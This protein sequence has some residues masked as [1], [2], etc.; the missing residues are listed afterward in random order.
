MQLAELLSSDQE[1]AS[2]T[3]RSRLGDIEAATW[4]TFQAL[5][6]NELGRLSPPAVRYIVHNYFAKEHGWLIKGLEPQGHRPNASEVHDV[7]VLQDKAPALVEAFLEDRRSDRGLVLSD[8]VAMIAVLERFI[9]DESLTLL[10]ASYTLNGKS[11]HEDLNENELHGVLQSYLLIFAQGHKATSNATRHQAYKELQIRHRPE[12]REY[13]HNAVLNYVYANRHTTN[14]FVPRRYTLQ[15]AAEIVRDMAHRYGK[16]QNS[17]C[18]QMKDHLIELDPTGFGRVP[19]SAFYKEDPQSVYHFSESVDYLR[20]IGALDESGLGGAK[21]LASNYILGP[22]NCIAVSD[23]YSVCCLNECDSLMNEL[24]RQAQAPAVAPER[25]LLLASQLSSDSVDAPREL[26]SL[27]VEKLHEIAALHGGQV[28]LHGRL[29]A[30]WLHYAF[31]FECPYPSRLESAQALTPSAWLD[32]RHTSD[33]EERAHHIATGSGASAVDVNDMQSMSHWTEDEILPLDA[34]RR[35]V[36]GAA[37]SMVLLAV[38]LVAVRTALPTIRS[39]LHS[40]GV[41]E[42]KGDDYVLPMRI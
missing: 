2:N 41:V 18:S 21:V 27:L 14:P 13:E 39:S 31:P 24:E 29:F 35:A 1:S 7:S 30:Q 9:V 40:L 34:P 16:W 26:P 5:P 11:V 42:K 25:L 37:R 15:A 8:I 17:D 6:K 28:P 32:G 36:L 4:Q 10:E 33:K 22:S 23:Y 19:L 20:Q 38:I 3:A 12:V